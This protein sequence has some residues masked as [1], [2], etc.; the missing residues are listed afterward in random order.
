ASGASLTNIL[1]RKKFC[2]IKFTFSLD[3]KKHLPK[4]LSLFVLIL[5]QNI[6]NNS[7]IT[8]IGI[9]KN[10]SEVGYYSTAVK[11]SG[12]ITKVV[13]SIALIVKTQSSRTYSQHNYNEI[14]LTVIRSLQFLDGIGFLMC[15]GIIPLSKDI[16]TILSG[17]EYQPAVPC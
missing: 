1:Y 11:V 14:N 15:F 6:Y 12:I 5:V 4:I 2:K 16:I 17:K 3:I 8:M 9:F 13:A 10:N 7:D